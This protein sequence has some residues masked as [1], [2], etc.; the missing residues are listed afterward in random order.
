MCDRAARE[1]H[2][3][4]K[5]RLESQFPIPKW[6][7]LSLPRLPTEQEKIPSAM[8]RT[9]V[10]S[11][12]TR[13][14]TANEALI[15][16]SRPQRRKVHTAAPSPTKKPRVAPALPHLDGFGVWPLAPDIPNEEKPTDPQDLS[17]VDIENILKNK[18][19]PVLD[20]R[21]EPLE[22]PK[23]ENKIQK[24]VSINSPKHTLTKQQSNNSGHYT[25]HRSS[26]VWSHVTQSID[27][28]AL[29]QIKSYEE[30]LPENPPSPKNQ[31]IAQE[32]KVDIVNI[33]P[34]ITAIPPTPEEITEA[35]VE[36]NNEAT[37][38]TLGEITAPGLRR[39]ENLRKL[40]HFA[41]GHLRKKIFRGWS[42]I[43]FAFSG[44]DLSQAQVERV[45]TNNN[46]CIT[47]LD[48]ERVHSTIE[49]YF[50]KTT[51]TSRTARSTESSEES[52]TIENEIIQVDVSDTVTTSE[53]VIPHTI[54][55]EVMQELFYPHDEKE[56][57]NWLAEMEAERRQILQEEELRRQKL[58]ELEEK[59]KRRLAESAQDMW[60]VLKLF[61][62]MHTT[63]PSEQIR[64]LTTAKFNELVCE[65]HKKTKNSI[66]WDAIGS[67]NGE[68]TTIP[69]I[70][71]NEKEEKEAVEEPQIVVK[72]TI[73]QVFRALLQSFSRNRCLEDLELDEAAHVFHDIAATVLQNGAKAFIERR[74]IYDTPERQY[75][76]AFKL[77]KLIFRQWRQNVNI[78]LT[79]RRMLLRK[80]VVWK[81]LMNRGKW[82]RELFRI[83][84]WPLYVW[85][86]WT[87]FVLISR[88]KAIFLHNV[89]DIYYALRHTRAW[90][91]YVVA[92]RKI[93]AE[94]ARRQLIREHKIRQHIFN[95]WKP[96]A[97]YG[98]RLRKIW[99]QNGLA[100]QFQTQFYTTKLSLYLWRYYTILHRDMDRRQYVCFHGA[101]QRFKQKDS[102][103]ESNDN[104][105]VHLT[106]INDSPMG[107]KVKH[108][109]RLHDLCITTYV[110]YR[111]KDRHNILIKALMFKR[112]APKV[113]EMLWL[114]KEKKKRSRFATSF[115]IF[116]QVHERF[117]QWLRFISFKRQ[118][119]RQH[120]KEKFDTIH[121]QPDEATIPP[122]RHALKWK[123]DKEWREKGLQDAASEAIALKEAIEAH[124]IARKASR[125]RYKNREEE[126]DNIHLSEQE[127]QEEQ[128]AKTLQMTSQLHNYANQIIHT[129]VRKLYEVIC[130]TF[131]IFEDQARGYM[132]KSTFRSLRVPVL[133]KK[134]K[135]L[136]N[137]S[138]LRN[139]LRLATRY[140]YWLKNMP[141]YYRLKKMH[142]VWQ[143]WA[144]FI[145]QRQLYESPGLA[146][147]TKRR[148][149][150]VT[151]FER[152]L[153]NEDFML[154]PT[155]LEQKLSYNSFRAVFM[156]WVE[157]TQ[158]NK[159]FNSL[160]KAF[161]HRVGVR[162][163]GRIFLAWK[164]NI[165][166]KYVSLP[167]SWLEKRYAADIERLR[168]SLW[169]MRKHLVSWRIRKVLRAC[170]RTLKL[171]VC[172]NPTLKNLFAM[173]TKVVLQRL[174]LEN[175]LM[176]VAYNERRIHHY[177]ERQTT[178]HG[179]IR[180]S[181][182]DY[183]PAISFGH[184][185][186]VIVVCGKSVDGLSVVVKSFNNT[187][188]GRLC[189][190][191]FGTRSIFQLSSHELLVVVEGYASQSTLL[192]L[193]F[194]T[195]HGRHSK[196]YGRYDVGSHFLLEAGQDEE[197]IGFH[198]YAGKD[199][200]HGIGAVFRRTT[201]RNIF[202]GLWTQEYKPSN[203]DS[204]NQS[205]RQFSYFL[206]MRS[207]DVY[208]A[209]ERAHRLALRMWRSE[210]THEAVN[211]LRIVMGLCEWFF[212]SLT[213]GLVQLSENEDEGQR[214]LQEGINIRVSGEK[215]LVDGE[216]IMESVKE[217]RNG[218]KQQ[219]NV[220]VLGFKKIQE[221]RQNIEISEDKIKRGKQLIAQGNNVIL[222]G[223]Q[224]LPKIPLSNSMIQY[225]KDLYRIVLT[226]DSMDSMG[227]GIRK[228][229][230]QDKDVD[231]FID[232]KDV[233][234]ARANAAF[235]MG[236]ARA[237]VVSSNLRERATA[238]H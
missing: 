5:A 91:R 163:M 113:F 207:C 197:I 165:K 182:F 121:A 47:K 76:L 72:R 130:R 133:M 211:R 4:T 31:D 139:W 95:E 98:Q 99:L 52:T 3:A 131:D 63:W 53:L 108:K 120:G 55:Y 79:R 107:H 57:A 192:G 80:F 201:E 140:A 16:Y 225:V 190:N 227:E 235:D 213:H 75:F 27:E 2:E 35:V 189:G 215:L 34:V 234:E 223:R 126:I 69:T 229:L 233:A 96:R 25:R 115:G 58:L 18:Q 33:S 65:T 1:R 51:R 212:N 123:A 200:V 102:T 185:H 89:F 110:K 154:I 158:L 179:A 94:L 155:V 28:L 109:T 66:H 11:A 22:K 169:A 61:D 62:Y 237:E 236:Q 191:P 132:L 30:E 60:R 164:H 206:Q 88:A 48:L 103:S 151:K 160:L 111:K 64:A 43:E 146:L 41:D 149:A 143:I 209:M 124:R 219:L 71:N 205:D 203:V 134:F 152:Y 175:R 174:S 73:G 186:Q 137:R 166:A 129:R 6:Y 181:K 118:L 231:T 144:E 23:P 46:I 176:F 37:P 167:F 42:A 159:C 14:H 202:E 220:A 13:Q 135:I 198:G 232:M 224:M 105:L 222:A 148:R 218:R 100:L 74:A 199:S 56:A 217:F 82:R 117:V 171:S 77:K 161:H 101:L 40:V 90:H 36:E 238:F 114:Y 20:D 170:D 210:S 106:R 93:D 38:E 50:L 45:L 92:Q 153:L 19:I 119:E 193:R 195:N 116:H 183:E 150:L 208:A 24:R 187:T 141:R 162:T 172:S 112:A 44:G 177:D 156:R 15:S 147:K 230:L 196:W 157:W 17:S 136:F 21:W 216:K 39:R 85:K 178:M 83:C 194:G 67:P 97:Q 29:H 7:D 138:Q 188:E 49:D 10:R 125:E 173:H 26:H 78:R 145:R 122:N 8:P 12:M 84:F 87:Q 128:Q 184:I 127:I 168:S 221:L 86:R 142:H 59:I 214:I 68:D 180:G 204:I 228:L 226:K 104:D 70:V 9:I 54:S 81:Y 32:I